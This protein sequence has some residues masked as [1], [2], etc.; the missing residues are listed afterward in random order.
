MTS[1][2]SSLIR[3]VMRL[4]DNFRVRVGSLSCPLTFVLQMDRVEPMEELLSF[5]SSSYPG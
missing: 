3:G 2:K 4:F 5:S 1:A